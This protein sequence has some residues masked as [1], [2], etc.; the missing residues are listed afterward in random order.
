M[1]GVEISILVWLS[2]GLAFWHF[3]VFMPDRFVGG[4]AGALTV[5]L[6]GATIGGVLLPVPGIPSGN[7]P[8]AMTMVGPL[9]GAPL[10]L[11]VSYALGR[12]S[13]LKIR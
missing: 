13:G 12:S 11:G 10:A 3:C 5:S 1:T 9:V 7:P 4:I 6:V 2:L 8:G